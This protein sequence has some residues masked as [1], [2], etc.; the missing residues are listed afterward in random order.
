VWW[1]SVAG[2]GVGA[3]AA[4]GLLGVARFVPIPWA[5]PAALA[6]VVTALVGAV[7]WAVAV[8]PSPAR[9]AQEA[10]R[11]LGGKDRLTTSVELARSE[12]AAD[13]QQVAAAERWAEGVHDLGPL[14]PEPPPARLVGVVGAVVVAAIALF[15]VPGPADAELEG[16]RAA[17]AA[18]SAI[19]DDLDAVADDPNLPDAVADRI[20][21]L[22]E[23]LRGLDDLDAVAAALAEARNDL[24]AARD[25]LSGARRAALAALERTLG[26]PDV[27]GALRDIAAQPPSGQA[28]AD[29]ADALDQRAADLTGVD[30]G[31]AAALEALARA[32][33][34]GGDVARAA[35]EAARA[36]G[37]LGAAVERADA[38]TAAERA[39]RDAQER[40]AQGEGEGS[41]E[42][43]GEGEGQGSGEGSGEGQGS[44]EGEGQGSGEGEGQGQG[45]GEG[46]GQGSGQGEGQGSGEGQGQGQ[47]QGG[48]G[49]GSVGGGTQGGSGTG[50][51]QVGSGPGGDP[52]RPP[53]F[54][55]I[56]DVPRVVG[57]DEVRVDLDSIG[58]DGTI[59]G[60]VGGA[61]SAN[62]PTVSYADGFPDYLRRALDALGRPD[63]PTDAR[64]L[65]R[66]YFREIE[67]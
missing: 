38:A 26:T 30:P 21:A 40:L 25:P 11:R 54:G 63:I 3:A 50:S 6:V 64:D 22:V 10:D 14:G 31:L 13:R 35:E 57:A 17:Q 67:P 7:G 36:A 65:V 58:T 24:E 48:G 34:E 52:E 29:L 18:A 46:E 41:G 43:S 15:V 20:E 42:G 44:G 51:G 66:D 60:P 28:A 8:R 59:T 5:D 19:A 55:Q 33:R 4:A 23:R 9:L 37:E 53:T 61:G 39:I 56:V 2:V 62:V 12:A 45:S 1:A 16:R 47:G 27:A 49:S 32:L